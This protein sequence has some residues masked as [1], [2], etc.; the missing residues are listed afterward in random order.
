MSRFR[1]RLDPTLLVNDIPEYESHA[2]TLSGAAR[3]LA[4]IA[5]RRSDVLFEKKKHSLRKIAGQLAD[6][7]FAL[8]HPTLWQREQ[9]IPPYWEVACGVV[10]L[11]IEEVPDV[12]D[13]A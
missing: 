12:E 11:S 9:W 6:A 5:L 4:L 13:D 8:D 3:T 10:L 2:E 1:V 7:S